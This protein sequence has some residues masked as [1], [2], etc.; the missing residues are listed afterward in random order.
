MVVFKRGIETD[1]RKT[2]VIKNWPLLKTVTDMVS[3]L[4]FTNYYRRLIP[5]YAQ[6]AKPLNQLILGENASKKS[7][8][9]IWSKDCQKAFDMLKEVCTTT[10]T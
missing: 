7:K 1:P 9:V 5:K 4:R 3:F 10:P 6:V 8:S 2:E